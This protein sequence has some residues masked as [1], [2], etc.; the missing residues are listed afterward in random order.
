V[1]ELRK[2]IIEESESQ[3]I[4]E[5]QL[6]EFEDEIRALYLETVKVIFRPPQLAN[7]DNDPLLP[8]KIYFD[9]ESADRAF[10]ALKSLAE[11]QRENDLLSDATFADSLVEKAEIP[12]L[13][14]TGEARKQLGGPVL[15]GTINIENRKL[16]VSVNSTRRAEKIRQL[17]EELLADEASYKTTLIAP[18]ESEVER[19]RQAAAG[20]GAG[21]Q[22]PHSVISGAEW[23]ERTDRTGKI[24]LDDMPSEFQVRL[25][26]VV[27]QRWITWLDLP[28]PALNDMTPREATKTEEGR[29]LLESLL[30]LYESHQDDPWENLMSPDVTALRRELGM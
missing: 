2:W 18:I 21:G 16:I 17:I 12:W 8:Q 25:K 27:R 19:L 5:D 10:H 23:A 3:E 29:D 22:P 20:K 30:L 14:G 15:L 28:V 7:T 24:S 6:N 11:W 9:I 4:T 26:E 13:G 1:L